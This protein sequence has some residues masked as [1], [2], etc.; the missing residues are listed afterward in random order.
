MLR[1]DGQLLV[2]RL[3]D[4]LPHPRPDWKLGSS[5]AKGENWGG[6]RSSPSCKRG[7]EAGQSQAGLTLMHKATSQRGPKDGCF[8][9]VGWRRLLRVL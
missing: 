7:R 8:P 6:I 4:H 9:T 3:G 1:Q 2:W 5:G